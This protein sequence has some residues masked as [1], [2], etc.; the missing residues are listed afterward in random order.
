MKGGATLLQ[1]E[2]G[3]GKSLC[4]QVSASLLSNAGAGKTLVLVPL[5]S[6]MHNQFKNLSTLGLPDFCAVL[7][8]GSSKLERDRILRNL[9]DGSTKLIYVSPEGCRSHWVQNMLSLF[10]FSLLVLDEAQ[11]AF[12]WGEGFRP[13][14]NILHILR[15]SQIVKPRS[16]LFLTAALSP[17]MEGEDSQVTVLKKMFNVGTVIMGCTSQ[18]QWD[19]RVVHFSTSSTP[20]VSQCRNAALNRQFETSR[21][22][23]MNMD[24]FTRKQSILA[25]CLKSELR[26]GH[27]VIVFCRTTQAVDAVHANLKETWK[28]VQAFKY[29]A[30]MSNA[31]R[32]KTAELFLAAQNGSVMIATV[33]WGM[34]TDNTYVGSI[35]FYD[36]PLSV[37]DALQG[38]GRARK[39]GSL[40]HYII[41]NSKVNTV[42]R[43]DMLTFGQRW[44]SDPQPALQKFLNFV[45]CG[46]DS[47]VAISPT[48]EFY[49]GSGSDKQF[50]QAQLRNQILFKLEEE[51]HLVARS[52]SSSNEILFKCPK[53]KEASVFKLEIINVLQ[54]ALD[55]AMLPST[56]QADVSKAICDSLYWRGT[57]DLVFSK[58]V[59]RVKFVAGVPSSDVRTLKLDEVFFNI[60]TEV[61]SICIFRKIDVERVGYVH[62]YTICNVV[63][64]KFLGTLI[65]KYWDWIVQKRKSI[66]NDINSVIQFV[67]TS[68]C[69]ACFLLKYFKESDVLVPCSHVTGP[70]TI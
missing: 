26:K 62:H 6:I 20:S 9:N 33:A 7:S 50:F 32:Q 12:S 49:S 61:K 45:L 28:D 34:G 30:R 42:E 64:P 8:A 35:I 39:E 3:A 36:L 27:T 17:S 67:T 44:L 10:H 53:F 54:L 41:C 63:E 52:S 59:F 70:P 1:V 58:D 11:C 65:K 51:D 57:M 55:D 69:R 4:F 40:V 14:I 47:T 38:F 43:P 18:R 5:I 23:A 13:A 22:D 29:H 2:T 15:V 48:S 21:Q 16:V 60:C 56:V 46:R 66:V 68:D 37:S 19:Y 24:V 31:D 25:E